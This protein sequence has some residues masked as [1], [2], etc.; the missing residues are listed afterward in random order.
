[1]SEA[2]PP[3]TSTCSIRVLKRPASN[4]WRLPPK[5]L[6]TPRRMDV[7][8]KYRFFA[9]L[10]GG[11]DP[12]SEQV[13]LLHIEQRSGARMKMGVAT[14]HW[15]RNLD[16]YV[17]SANELFRSMTEQG[18]HDFYA[19]PIDPSQELLDG[20]HRL[21]CAL[22]LDLETVP[23][24]LMDKRVWAPSWGRDWFMAKGMSGDDLERMASDWELLTQ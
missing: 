5:A 20:S 16:D 13:Y 7:A 17:T 6:L 21:A 15:K 1:M 19:V 12:G 10:L 2:S 23:V 4:C 22:A 8:V 18:F 24:V 11:G 9:H 14:D 3:S